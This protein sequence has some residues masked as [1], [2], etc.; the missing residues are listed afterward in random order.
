MEFS[1]FNK[2]NLSDAAVNFFAQLNIALN[3]SVTAE[4]I[5]AKDYLREQFKNDKPFTSINELYFTGLINNNIFD[6]AL[7]ETKYTLE[8]AEKE[9]SRTK[10]KYESIMVFA[11]E[12]SEKPT[13]TQISKLTSAFNYRKKMPY[14]L[15][16]KYNDYI[17]LALPELSTYK[18]SWLHDEKVGKVIILRD[19]DTENTHAGHLRILQDLANHNAHNFNELHEAWLKVLDIQTLNK[20]FYNRLVAWY[21]KC[22]GDIQINLNA[23]SR[24]L[25]KKIDDELKPQAVIRIIIR[26]MFLWFMKEKQLIDNKFFTRKFAAEFLNSENNYYNAILQNIFF[27]VLNKKIDER[28]FRLKNNYNPF[29]PET[30]DYGVADVLRYKSMFKKGKDDEFL[31]ETKRIPY[32]NGGLFQCH[33]Y[34]FAG[35]DLANNKYNRDHNYIIDGFTERMPARVSADT[36]FALIDL[37]NDYVFTIEESTPLEQDI[38]LDPELLGTIFENL[39][40]SYNPETKENARK[41][42]GSFYTPREIVDYMCKE[43]LREALK[44]KLPNLAAIIDNLID[45]DADNFV[46]LRGSSCNQLLH[47]VHREDTKL[48]KETINFQIATEIQNTILHLKILDPACG[49]GAFLMGMFNLMVKI[50]EKLDSRKTTYQNKLD[51]IQNCIYGIDIQNIAVEISKLRFFISLLVDYD[52]DLEHIERFEVLPNLETK[53]VVANSLIGIEK[54]AQ[55]DIFGVNK[56]FEELTEAFLPFTTAKTP[57]EKEAIKNAFETKKQQIISNPD[58]E[59]GTD[60]KDKIRAW[61][62]FNVSY[63]SPFFD[64]QIMFGITDGFD[65]VIGNPPYGATSTAEQKRYFRRNYR[66]AKT[67]S[68]VQKGSVETFTLFIEKG[69]NLLKTGNLHYIVPTSIISSD[70][71]TALHKLLEENCSEIKVSSYAVH[72]QPVF[73]NAVVNTSILFFKKDNKANEKI[74]ATKMYR[75]DKNFNLQHIVNNLQFID[76]KKVK[77]AGRYP[78]ISLAI[79]KNILTKIFSRKKTIGE[80]IK[81][82]GKPIFYRTANGR[83]FNVITNY[84]TGSTKD[85]PI[86]FDEQIADVVGACLISNLFFWFYH[87]FSNNLDLK[88][89]E[90]ASFGFPELEDNT[91]EK[92]KKLYAEYLQDIENKANKRNATGKSK[93]KVSQFKEYKIG[94]SKHLID[95]IDDLICPLY[96]LTPEE[97]EFIKNYEIG[98]QR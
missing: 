13:R 86:I 66:S 48:L 83:Y 34:V 95:K 22:Y 43:S 58:F 75:K 29:D 94:N 62:P 68:G 55:N 71:M 90:I 38:A 46:N 61:N 69:F 54:N 10:E 14:L 3:N 52:Y 97:T 63:C 6:K 50:V 42:T 51:I 80:L 17:S 26:M 20:G 84:S 41:Q 60:A 5:D 96:D 30:N 40:A 19:I 25:G 21:D 57:K 88:A 98:F 32:V 33:D 78:K 7:F 16:L 2:Q 89:Y 8:D 47:E 65:I 76:V 45:D 77:L 73:E 59:F 53:F 37:F 18:Q 23:A 49:S 72:P 31:Q 11:L 28:R 87:I 85:K 67:V 15:L 39:I 12:L 56:A 82:Q 64:S 4:N 70:S 92:L 24:E 9:N 1:Y 44:T 81:S 74:L 93:H 35:K 27:A 79:E 91:I 36:M